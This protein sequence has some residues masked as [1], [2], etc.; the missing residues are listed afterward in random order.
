MK[1]LLAIVGITLTP[2]TQ[3]IFNLFESYISIALWIKLAIFFVIIL[4][5]G[6]CYYF[7]SNTN[8]KKVQ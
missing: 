5:S 6:I 8:N 2:V 3:F 1:K 7:G 4:I